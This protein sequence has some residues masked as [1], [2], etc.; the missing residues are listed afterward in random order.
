[1]PRSQRS[2]SMALAAVALLAGACLLSTV[3]VAPS[4]HQQLARAASPVALR[5]ASGEY[6][7]FVPDM[8]RRT[9][10]NL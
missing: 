10:M 8:Q 6:T 4:P 9:L 5:S 7:G 3:F 2:R 1:M